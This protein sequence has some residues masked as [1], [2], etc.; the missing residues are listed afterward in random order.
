MREYDAVLDPWGAHAQ[1]TWSG[2]W[3]T[4]NLSLAMTVSQS[5]WFF[6]VFFSKREE[7]DLVTEGGGE[8][9]GTNCPGAR[10]GHEWGGSC[11]RDKSHWEGGV[12]QKAALCLGLLRV[13]RGAHSC[14]LHL[15]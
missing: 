9:G 5:L 6:V 2:V 13:V 10:F 7:E 12:A 4:G 15:G 1:G 14:C 3:P 11:L 8:R